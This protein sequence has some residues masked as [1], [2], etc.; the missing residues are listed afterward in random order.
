MSLCS[1]MSRIDDA[2]LA[3]RVCWLNEVTSARV[4][5]IVEDVVRCDDLFEVM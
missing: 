3:M 1:E 2:L 5:T 4:H